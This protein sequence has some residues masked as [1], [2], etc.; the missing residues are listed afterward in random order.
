[1]DL[2]HPNRQ[3][4]LTQLADTF[5]T[6]AYIYDE[7]SI[8]AQVQMLR[9][10]IGDKPRIL[11]SVKANP[12][13][14]LLKLWNELVDG[15]EVCSLGEYRLA[16]QAGVTPDCLFFVGPGKR[17]FELEE[18]LQDNIAGVI[19]ES[20]GELNLLQEICSSYPKKLYVELRIN[21]SV[22]VSGGRLNMSGTPTQFGFSEE[23]ALHLFGQNNDQFPNLLIEGAHFYFGTQQLNGDVLNKL[24]MASVD[25]V[26]KICALRNQ[27]QLPPLQSVDFGGGFGVPYYTGETPLD[28][29]AIKEWRDTVSS[30]DF[31]NLTIFV[32]SGR[33]LSAACGL[34]LTRVLYK[35]S[36]RDKT[37]LIVDGGMNNHFALASIGRLLKRDFPVT[38]LVQPAY[39]ED[40]SLHTEKVTIAGPL[41]TP[42]DTLATNADLPFM[43]E[44]DLIAIP[45]AG[46]YGYTYSP[47]LFLSHPAPAEILVHQNLE[48]EIIRN[49]GYLQMPSAL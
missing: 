47:Q 5:G 35:K 23:D 22:S 46:A 32:E 43:K 29:S 33:F 16:R 26:R 49:G 21:P 20:L 2:S 24:L 15:M 31:K 44:G 28:F 37:F 30:D 10:G 4:E 41:C 13:P 6:P 38:P 27:N 42:V 45:N 9:Q 39:N 1:M 7:E 40:G 19:A 3:D 25:I 17:R 12:N 36:L 8:R 34:F 48:A 11:Y 18:I 14:A